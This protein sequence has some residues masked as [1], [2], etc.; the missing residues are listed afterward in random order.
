MRKFDDRR[1]RRR[2]RRLNLE[3]GKEI[4]YKDDRL[5][6]RF[7]TDRGKIVPRRICKLSAKIMGFYLIL[8]AGKKDPLQFLSAMQAEIRGSQ[9][10]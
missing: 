4:D 1:D 10:W 2:V 7:I 9:N 8:K 6:R 3:K 5:I